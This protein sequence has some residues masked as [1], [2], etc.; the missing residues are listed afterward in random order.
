MRLTHVVQQR[1]TVQLQEN[2]PSAQSSGVESSTSGE[3]FDKEE[4]KRLF[5]QAK[6]FYEN[7][8]YRQAIIHFER[9]RQMPGI[10]EEIKRPLL[11]NIGV[12]NIRLRRFATAIFYLEQYISIPGADVELARAHL[13]EAKSG[14]GISPGETTTDVES[15]SE[16]APSTS[17]ETF[18]KEEARELFTR[19]QAFY[20]V[21]QYRQ[22]IIHFERCRQISGMPASAKRDMLYNIGVSNLRLRRF[23]TAIFYF[24]QYLSMPG[25]DEESA[26]EH[27]QEAQRGAGIST[28]ERTTT[29]FAQEPASTSST[30]DLTG[31]RASVTPLGSLSGEEEVEEQES[32]RLVARD[33][34]WLVFNRY[35]FRSEVVEYL[36]GGSIRPTQEELY[37]RSS[38]E[39]AEDGIQL[40]IGDTHWSLAQNAFIA[41]PDLYRRLRPEVQ[42]Q[43]EGLDNEAAD[44]PLAPP[45]WVPQ[46]VWS[47]F[48]VVGEG[49][50][51]YPTASPLGTDIILVK[52]SNGSLGGYAERPTDRAQ[53]FERLGVTPPGFWEAISGENPQQSMVRWLADEN[54]HY[55]AFMWEQVSSGT[56]VREAHERYL[57]DA[58]SRAVVSAL[59]AIKDLA[60]G[61]VGG[62]VIEV[63]FAWLTHPWNPTLD[64][65]TPN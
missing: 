60:G 25:A 40:D 31:Q 43:M 11:Y 26:R 62:S 1:G 3:T 55:N 52:H 18:D 59:E 50:H 58:Q 6:E 64:L 27:L 34:G 63:I 8:Q 38:L 19:A 36:W 48:L 65:L 46:D 51:R 24:E 2:E 15:T 17:E 20:Q 30:G 33:G 21:G 44:R 54:R 47:N 61:P 37:S 45:A 10:S 53:L 14:L 41:R 13:Q 4:G 39:P 28:G 57:R 32:L 35:A 29:S 16:T 9:L 5:N 49:A 23:A 22:A 56:T 12:S 42:A 7:G